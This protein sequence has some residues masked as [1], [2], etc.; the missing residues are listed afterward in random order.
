MP[1]TKISFQLIIVLILYFSRISNSAIIDFAPGTISIDSN[2]WTAGTDQTNQWYVSNYTIKNGY[3]ELTEFSKG[4]STKTAKTGINSI[5]FA[6][7]LTAD[8]IGPH[9]WS[10]DTS[11]SN[12]ETQ[13]NYGQVLLLKPGQ[14][15][16]LTK[17]IWNKPP[18][19]AVLVSSQQTESGT[20]E[21]SRHSYGNTFYISQNDVDNFRYIIFAVTGSK[22]TEHVLKYDRLT[23]NVYV[24]D[25]IV[26][27]PTTI[28]LITLGLL[29]L[30]RKH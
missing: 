23:D 24:E 30:I 21:E 7:D 28:V 5:L 8:L 6:L 27:E 14:T 15:I 16:K 11:F 4:N 18:G 20:D 25:T 12:N 1:N 17:D 26:P 3:A 19:G 13:Y 9:T 2:T 22:H 10:I 29:L